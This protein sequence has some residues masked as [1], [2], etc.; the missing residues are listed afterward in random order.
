MIRRRARKRLGLSL[1][2][3]LTALAIF[4]LS[5]VVLSQMVDSA[6]QMGLR[7]KRLTK[8]A[9]LCEAKMDEVVAGVQPLQAA[10]PQ[11]L[12]GAEAGWACTVVVEPQSW[13]AVTSGGQQSGPGLNMVH[14]T[15]VWTGKPMGGPV[16]YTL[17]RLV[18]DPHLRVPAQT[19]SSSNSTSST[20]SP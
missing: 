3:V 12:E 17:S 9:V 2:E 11:P 8:A 16:E 5:V 1:L 14:V 6:A 4:L 19:P 18:L 10:G 7:S 20:S 13:S 15:V